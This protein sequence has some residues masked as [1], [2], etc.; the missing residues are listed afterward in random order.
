MK[1]AET[2]TEDGGRLVIRQTHDFNPTLK[3]ASEL[4]SHGM[5]DLG[6]SKLVGLVP[7]KMW[8]EWAKAAGVSAGDHDAMREVV[9]RNLNSPDYAHLRVWEGKY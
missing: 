6:E 3:A 8:H 7:L 1:I 2:Y 9:A 5:G 4:R